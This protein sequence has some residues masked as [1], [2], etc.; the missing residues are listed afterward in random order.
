MSTSELP[1]TLSKLVSEG[2]NPDTM[3]LD[4]LSSLELVTRINTQDKL[5][6][7][8]VEKEL[9]EIAKAVDMIGW[10]YWMP[11]SALLPSESMNLWW[12]G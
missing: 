6:P 2:R 7:Q 3:D 1:D 8:A 11:Q 5:V 9:P 4:T 12:S 10:V